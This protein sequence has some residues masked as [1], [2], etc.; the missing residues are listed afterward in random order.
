MMQAES[1]GL[2]VTQYGFVFG[3]FTFGQLVFA[4][5]TGSL[6]R[7]ISPKYACVAGMF[8][9]GCSTTAFAFLHWSPPGGSTSA[10]PLL[11]DS[12]RPWDLLS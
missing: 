11:W 9:I 1:K 5:L 4:P 6:V 3:S 12:A 10:S 7:I 2:S 8:I